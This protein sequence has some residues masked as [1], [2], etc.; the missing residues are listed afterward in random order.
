MKMIK[1]CV[2][3]QFQ[4]IIWAPKCLVCALCASAATSHSCLHTHV[5]SLSMMRSRV[6]SMMWGW[7]GGGGLGVVRQ[8]KCKC[9]RQQLFYTYLM[10][11]VLDTDLHWNRTPCY[12]TMTCTTHMKSQQFPLSWTILLVSTDDR[13]TSTH[14]FINVRHQTWAYSER[15]HHHHHHHVKRIE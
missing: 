6:C 10:S 8:K 15:H 9:A 5:C 11:T 13:W 14:T 2:N 3:K 12:D 1:Y 7:G 4:F